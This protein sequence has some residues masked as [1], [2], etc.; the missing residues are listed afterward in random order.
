MILPKKDKAGSIWEFCFTS[1]EKQYAQCG[2][3]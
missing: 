3:L 2:K 1:Q